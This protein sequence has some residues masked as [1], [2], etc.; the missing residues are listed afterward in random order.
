MLLNFESLSYF[1]VLQA[2]SHQ[3]GHIFLATRQQR[4]SVGIVKLNWLHL[5]KSGQ[6]M[7]KVLGAG[8]DFPLVDHPYT[9]REVFQGISAT[10]NTTCTLTKS[11]YHAVGRGV[12]HEHDGSRALLR[13]P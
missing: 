12:L 11:I 2:V 1:A 7:F 10:E 5:N 6:N 8:P 4:V 13:D 9:F 3:P